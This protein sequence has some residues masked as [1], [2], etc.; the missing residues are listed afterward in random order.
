MLW[1]VLQVMLLA[2]GLAMLAFI[3]MALIDLNF[4]G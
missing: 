3:W 1:R 2:A 4:Q